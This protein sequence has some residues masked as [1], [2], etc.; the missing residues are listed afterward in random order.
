MI[1]TVKT[2]NHVRKTMYNFETLEVK[3]KK[4][5]PIKVC[6]TML[7]FK[8]KGDDSISNFLDVAW[9]R[10]ISSNVYCE[11]IYNSLQLNYP[12]L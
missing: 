5:L 10:I 11:V 9:D 4:S 2:I 6:K 8:A 12:Q 3:K 1:W 7:T